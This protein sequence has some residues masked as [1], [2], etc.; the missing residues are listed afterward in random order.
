MG[1]PNG[2]LD[3][4]AD[5]IVGQR[6]RYIQ[7][8][9]YYDQLGDVTAANSANLPANPFGTWMAAKVPSVLEIAMSSDQI[10]VLAVGVPT[11]VTSVG[12][13]VADSSAPFDPT[14]GPPLAAQANGSVWVVPTCDG[15][16]AA[17]RLWK[18]LLDP[19]TF[20]H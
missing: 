9:G 4:W 8:N 15:A 17:Q 7:V 18:M 1:W 11:F 13:A 2:E 14:T 19:R 10:G 3:P 12:W 6:F 20:G 5:W 16:M